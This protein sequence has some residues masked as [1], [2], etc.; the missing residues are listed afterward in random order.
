MKATDLPVQ[1]T[2]L[3]PLHR[4]LGARMVPFAGSLLPLHYQA[5]ILAEH[6]HTRTAVSLFDLSHMGQAR[7]EGAGFQGLAAEFE[8]LVPGDILGLA[9][10]QM[11]Y[12]VLVNADAGILDDL[13]VTRLA[14]QGEDDHLF[15]VVNGV[16]RET[17]F[18]HIRAVLGPKGP[19]LTALTDRALLAL[20]GPHAA[21][22]L[23][24]LAPSFNDAVPFMRAVFLAIAGIPC[25]VSRSGYTGEDGF[26]ISV[27]AG[28]ALALAERLLAEHDVRPAGLG[29][30][31][32]LR[33]EAG[34]CLYGADIDAT[35]SLLEAGLAWIIGARRWKEANFPGAGRL[36]AE[37]A[38]GP[39]R[40]RVGLVVEGRVPA[41]AQAVITDPAGLPI[42]VVTS[43]GVSPTLD[44]PIAMGYVPPGYASPGTPV[45][46]IVRAI[47][48]AAEVAPLPF[49]AHR[50]HN[51]KR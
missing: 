43:G 38:T 24:R 23:A 17:D 22:V 51:H 26:E 35:T 27:A 34:L 12:T 16:P 9:P 41:R 14:P 30:R 31:D 28:E 49:V 2:P 50:Y 37:R 19:L 5:G 21:A 36:L 42:G 29:A 47:P 46:I 13:M 3:A 32:S 7:L 8:H 10:G 1:E 20:Q 25:L 4:R 18:A 39:R 15:L 40:V 44:R 48:R 33:L 45:R 11:R 6:R